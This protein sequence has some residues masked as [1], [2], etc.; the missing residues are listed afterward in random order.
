MN[1]FSLRRTLEW[2]KVNNLFRKILMVVILLIADS[3]AFLL[4]FLLA[5]HLRIHVIPQNFSRAPVY[6]FS[7]YDYA[8]L[9]WL[10]APLSIFFFM[11]GL[12]FK[13]RPFQLELKH[14]F[15]A[16]IL[17]MVFTLALIT[18]VHLTGIISRVVFVFSI[19]FAALFIPALRYATKTVSFDGGLWKKRVLVLG[20]AKTGGLVAKSLRKDKFLG[21]QVM[22]FLDDDPEKAGAL[23]EGI[24]VLGK[25]SDIKE[26]L[27]DTTALD[28]IIAMPAL[29][30]ERLIEIVEL[31]E[32][33]V[34][35]IKIIPD[36]FGVATIGA[37]IESIS[38]FLMI[39][40]NI[41]LK[42]PWNIFIKRTIDLVLSTVVLIAGAPF[43]LL[44]ALAI[45]LDSPGPVLF[46][47][48]RLG[49]RDRKGRF[50]CFKFRTMYIDGPER[51]Q[52]YFDEHPE[53]RGEWEKFAKLRSGDPRVTAVG[54]WLR[55]TSVDE[56]PQVLNVLRG[57]MSL[58]GPRPYLPSEIRKMNRM[59]K[60]ILVAK[61]GITG[62]W[63]V[64]GRNE[65]SFEDRC[66]MDIYY[67]RNW[68]LWMD[69]VILVR[70]VFIVLSR[71]G[72]Y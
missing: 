71:K 21:Y 32:N 29:S 49:Q 20:A 27:K 7:L 38:E 2:I 17:Y 6:S 55:K 5:H 1:T 48:K 72:A 63:Q 54:R 3:G 57:D 52:K 22:G 66:K 4:S 28:V 61:P 43:F 13:R 14:I 36:F 8:P 65:L 31:C 26:T 70:T 30:R 9:W 24:R 53:K 67:V 68:S 15:K 25:T 16:L 59:E 58:V 46:I 64:S 40:I 62:L 45:K 47:Q 37:E 69:L 42:K 41:N 60:T 33:Y 50:P 56:F 35:S 10:I 23:I 39:N 44:I 19:V 11:E 34:E 51:L 18:L 12:Y